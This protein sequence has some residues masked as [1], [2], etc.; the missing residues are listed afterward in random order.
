M[1]SA[2]TATILS[3]P[4]YFR[5][6]YAAYMRQ[7]YKP[8]LFQ[9]MACRLLGTKALSAPMITCYQLDH[10]EPNNNFHIM[11]KC[12]NGY[13]MMRMAHNIHLCHT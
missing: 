10:R 1:S 6:L 7:N 9:M 3:R 12:V 13:D 2:K 4:E 5:R 8:P 11:G